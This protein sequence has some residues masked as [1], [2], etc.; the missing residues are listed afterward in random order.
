[1]NSHKNARL[2]FEGRKLLIERIAVMGLIP[3]ASAAGISLQIAR[4]WL[5]RFE[6]GGQDA[7]R[8]R[9]SR[10]DRTRSTIDS[11]LAERMER[12]RRARMPIRRIALTVGRS[13]ATISRV[14]AGLGCPA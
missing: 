9:S 8:D 5:R 6:E 10:P 1:M 13:V 2:T 7:L 4:K 14:L 11:E 3:A 12:L